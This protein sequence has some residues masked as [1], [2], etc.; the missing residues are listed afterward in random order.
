MTQLDMFIA[1]GDTITIGI[2]ITARRE[3]WAILVNDEPTAYFMTRADAEEL[4]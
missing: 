3:L 4:I 1:L 2:V